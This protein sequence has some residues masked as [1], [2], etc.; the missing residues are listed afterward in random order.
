MVGLRGI[1][2]L[3]LHGGFTG[4]LAHLDAAL[5]DQRAA[6]A[7]EPPPTPAAVPVPAPLLEAPRQ[8]S[9]QQAELVR[10]LLLPALLLLV[11]AVHQG[12]YIEN[13]SNRYKNRIDRIYSGSKCEIEGPRGCFDTNL[14][15]RINPHGPEPLDKSPMRILALCKMDRID[16]SKQIASQ[17]RIDRIEASHVDTESTELTKCHV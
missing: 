6:L 14:T 4:L 16:R 10:L 13:R 11:K 1:I 8:D 5:E 15:R 12:P 2:M 9:D 17:I 3:A 7:P